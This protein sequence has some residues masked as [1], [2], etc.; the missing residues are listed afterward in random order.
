MADVFRFPPFFPVFPVFSRFF[1]LFFFNGT[2]V[3]ATDGHLNRSVY[4][5]LS[6]GTHE[7]PTVH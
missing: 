5:A 3:R 1:L 4:I 2:G 7:T 6:T